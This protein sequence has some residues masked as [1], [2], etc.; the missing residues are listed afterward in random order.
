MKGIQ[1]RRGDEMVKWIQNKMQNW[2]RKNECVPKY[3]KMKH[4][5]MIRTVI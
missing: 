5:I 3:V 1:T 2:Y 4:Q